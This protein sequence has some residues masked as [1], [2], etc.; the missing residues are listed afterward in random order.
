MNPMAIVLSSIMTAI[1]VGV[2]AAVAWAF[3][4][5]VMFKHVWPGHAALT[6]DVFMIA[7][8]ATLLGAAWIWVKNLLSGW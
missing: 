5:A 8:V 6:D 4:G 3:A 1:L 7:V 2:S